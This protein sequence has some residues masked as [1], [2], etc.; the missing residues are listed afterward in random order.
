MNFNN[1]TVYWYPLIFFLQICHDNYIF[2]L[3]SIIKSL[4]T[5]ILA[6]ERKSFILDL[7]Y[8]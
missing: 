4:E 6:H 1:L 5:S 8:Y 3:C 2:R 7:I